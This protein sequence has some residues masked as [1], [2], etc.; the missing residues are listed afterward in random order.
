MPRPAAGA[1]EPHLDLSTL[2]ARGLV[3]LDEEDLAHGNMTLELGVTLWMSRAGAN[4]GA[5][6]RTLLDLRWALLSSSDLDEVSEP[7]PMMAGD[8][9]TAILSLAVYLHG[10]LQRAAR[11]VTATPAWMAEEALAALAG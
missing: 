3:S 11:S 2:L 10:L 4:L 8:E 6:R 7:I 9:R 5:V 1:I